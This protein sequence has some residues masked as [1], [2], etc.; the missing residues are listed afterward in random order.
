MNYITENPWPLIILLVGIAI[1]AAA[2]GASKGKS[3]TG[4]ALV[5]AVGLYFVEQYFISPAEELEM[6]VQVM[7][8]NFKSR[9]LDAITSQIHSDKPDLVSLA[10]KGFNMVE[11]A[12]S[13]AIKD[14]QVTMDSETTATA[15]IRANGPVVV[16]GYGSRRVATF[17]K[18]TWRKLDD[19]WQLSDAIQLHPVNGTELPPF[20]A[21]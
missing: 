1:V 16:N 8:D 3:L 12:E 13:F 15:M 5:L 2:S 7:L 18:T 20:S 4:I 9:D 17:W 19:S 6:E 14:V 21:Q 10:E 11:L